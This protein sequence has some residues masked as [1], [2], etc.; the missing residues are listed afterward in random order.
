MGGRT[1]EEASEGIIS[2]FWLCS[3]K[4]E[5]FNAPGMSGRVEGIESSEAAFKEFKSDVV[6]VSFCAANVKCLL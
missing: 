1:A 3:S 5:H 6:P 4:F 2:A